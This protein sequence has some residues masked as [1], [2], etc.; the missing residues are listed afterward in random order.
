MNSFVGFYQLITKSD[1]CV[2]KEDNRQNVNGLRP[3]LMKNY[4][5][6]FTS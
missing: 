2:R 6:V 5:Q 4:V 1:S 3:Y